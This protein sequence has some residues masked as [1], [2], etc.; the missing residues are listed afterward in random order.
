MVPPPAAFPARAISSPVPWP[1][2]GIRA[3]QI[4]LDAFFAFLAFRIAYELRYQYEVGG[5]VAFYDWLAFSQFEKRA[6]FFAVLAV[7]ILAVRGVY[8]LPRSTGLLDESVMIVGGLTTAIAGVILTAFLTRFVPSRLVFVYAWLIA[9]A[10][11]VLRRIISRAVRASLWKHGIYVDRV[12]VV[13]SGEAGRRVMEA[14]LNNP[15]LGYKLV[16]FVNDLPG[17]TYP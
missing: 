15:A 3:G 16:G 17:T 2:I 6:Y 7:V 13:G 9:I 10:L 12:L 4:L 11:F 1:R 14:M 5:N 8:W